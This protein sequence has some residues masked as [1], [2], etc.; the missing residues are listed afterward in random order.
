V[1]NPQVVRIFG[2]TRAAVESRAWTYEVWSGAAEVELE[3]LRLLAGY[4]RGWLFD[5]ELLGELRGADLDGVTLGEA[6]LSR[7][8]WAEPLVRAGILHLLWIQE[9]T[10]DL[11]R[12][13]SADHVLRRRA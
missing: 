10:T 2:W 8:G 12:P 7:Q 3:N 9:L 1:S 11:S 4:R 13:L 6:C 5:P